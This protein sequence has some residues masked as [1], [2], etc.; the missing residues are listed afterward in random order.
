MTTYNYEVFYESTPNN[1]FYGKIDANTPAEAIAAVEGIYFRYPV[2]VNVWPFDGD[3]DVAA[4]V[5]NDAT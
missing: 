4:L 3:A 1:K 5:V 2:K